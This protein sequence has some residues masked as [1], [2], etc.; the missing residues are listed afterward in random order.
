MGSSF[1][2]TM[3]WYK[4]FVM[5]W[6][7]PVEVVERCMELA[8]EWA[9]CEITWVSE[10]D[11]YKEGDNWF[12][13]IY[14]DVP[15]VV[16]PNDVPWLK[17]ITYGSKIPIEGSADY[18]ARVFRDLE[19]NWR[20]KFEYLAN[21]GLEEE[22]I[23]QFRALRHTAVRGEIAGAGASGDSIW[24]HLDNGAMRTSA[25]LRKAEQV[26]GEV[27]KKG[28]VMYFYL[29][30]VAKEETGYCAWLEVSRASKNFPA[31]LIR[32]Y[33]PWVKAKGI[34]R[35]VGKKSWV[36]CSEHP[37]REVLKKV[38]KELRGEVVEVILPHSVKP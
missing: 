34:R 8:L 1:R 22:T 21:T 12:A 23:R 13:V 24:V 32:M 28:D 15:G 27:Y 37:G 7:Y 4:N 30:K 38:S 29:S 26:P 20:D 3:N 33:A 2:R 18:W 31:A 19:D 16:N 6:R 11:V 17:G 10:C 36:R 9:L 5:D 14:L 35:I 25:E